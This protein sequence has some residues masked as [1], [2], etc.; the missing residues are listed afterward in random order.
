MSCSLEWDAQP[1]GNHPRACASCCCLAAATDFQVDILKEGMPTVLIDFGGSSG[2]RQ[3]TEGL[4]IDEWEI[5]QA[6]RQHIDTS[7]RQQLGSDRMRKPVQD[8]LDPRH[9]FDSEGQT[10]VL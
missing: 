10:N 2:H 3:D 7:V 1:H 9:T 4:V 5:S 6:E 8:W